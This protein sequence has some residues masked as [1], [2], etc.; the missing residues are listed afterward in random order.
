MLWAL[1]SIL[2][3]LGDA[4]IFALMKRLKG[5]DNSIVVW[6]QYAFALPFLSVLLYLNHP[7]KISPDVY[8]IAALNGTLLI[9]TT[10]MLVK[11]LQT[12]KLSVSLPMLSLTPL[13]LVVLSYVMLK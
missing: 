8:W 13:F 9:A 1:L 7:Q 12:S 3:G 10:Y 2:S 11:A 6:V 4:A 5:I